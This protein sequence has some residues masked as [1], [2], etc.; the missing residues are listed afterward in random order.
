MIYRLLQK[1][2]VTSTGLISLDKLKKKVFSS[3]VINKN[4]VTNINNIIQRMILATRVTHN[5]LRA[6]N[7]SR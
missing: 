7:Y 2:R 5:T 1:M 3:N 6:L 4:F